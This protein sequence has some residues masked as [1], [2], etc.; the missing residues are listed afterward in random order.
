MLL[1]QLL[2]PLRD[3]LPDFLV[4]AAER[5]GKCLLT[6]NKVLLLGVLQ[7][8]LLPLGGFFLGGLFL[9]HLLGLLD[10]SLLQDKL[11][12]ALSQQI[13]GNLQFFVGLAELGLRLGDAL[14]KIRLRLVRRYHPGF[15]LV[16]ASAVERLELL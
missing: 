15:R 8:L 11:L 5:G 4:L 7:G 16:Q 9:R 6:G 12:F 2:G 3:N 13:L 14:L 1:L 10:I